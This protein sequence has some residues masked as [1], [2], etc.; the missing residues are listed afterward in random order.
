MKKKILVTGGNGQV[1]TSLKH[2]LAKHPGYEGKVYGR[3]SFDLSNRDMMSR[4]FAEIAPDFVVNA[5][6][7]TKVDLAEE[8]Q[9]NAHSINVEACEHMARLCDHADI[10]ILHYSSDYVYHNG[11]DRPLLETDPVAPKSVYANTKHLGE[12]AIKH[13]NDKHFILRTSWVYDAFGTNFVR[14]MLGLAEKYPELT[15]VDDQIGSPTYAPDIAD[16]TLEIITSYFKTDFTPL[17]YGTYNFSNEGVC[18][19]YDFAKAIFEINHVDIAVR[20]VPSTAFPRPAARPNYSILNK[21][22]I[23]KLLPNYSIPH[24]RESLVRCLAQMRSE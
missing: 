2:A 15:V 11:L 3:Q 19:W 10:P 6:A 5:A 23:R 24:W 16:V 20:P 7:Y 9:V 8:D 22:K 13:L 18:S 12:E 21:A 14:T 17:D 4:V 1:G